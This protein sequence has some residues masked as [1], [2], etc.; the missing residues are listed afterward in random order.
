MPIVEHTLSNGQAIRLETFTGTVVSAD[1]SSRTSVHQ[2]AAEALS[3]DTV[4]PGRI[5]STTRTDQ[6][7]W[8]RTA[9]GKERSVTL[10][11]LSLPVRE[12]HLVSVLWGGPAHDER[13]YLFGA[14]NHTAD[15]LRCDVGVLKE[16]LREWKL[17]IGT[18]S[19]FMLWTF[20]L[21]AIGALWAYLGTDSSDRFGLAFMAGFVGTFVGAFVWTFV[22]FSFGP[23][24]RAL[25]LTEEINELG[26]QA[27]RAR[28]KDE[29]LLSLQ[30]QPAAAV[31]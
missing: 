22:G 11:D 6:A 13:T 23:G 26:G 29:H 7:L 18:A 28:G 17:S 16:R 20:G 21:A 4:I 9:D 8:L 14:F 10:R 12:G 25:A 19:S 24:R 2:E 15:A 31:A 5:Y 1:K 3:A 27:L 30:S